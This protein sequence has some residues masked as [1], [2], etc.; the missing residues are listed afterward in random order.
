MKKLFVMALVV[1]MAL[2]VVAVAACGP[3]STTKTAYGIV[4]GDYVGIATVTVDGSG[5]VTEATF[6]EACQPSQK[7]LT[8]ED[9][10]GL[11]KAD[12]ADFTSKHGTKQVYANVK[13]GNIEFVCKDGKYQ[14]GGKDFATYFAS[15]ANCEAYAK[16]VI[17]NDIQVKIGGEWKK[18]VIKAD[19]LLK[20]KNGYWTV[21]EGLGW[22]GNIK[23]ICDYVVANG[24]DKDVTFTQ[25]E[26]KIWTDS[27]KVSVGATLID[28]NDYYKVLKAAYDQK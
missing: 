19:N 3:T 1:V 26:D 7:S 10:K 5:K 28:F 15:E 24:L 16:A 21:S 11:D 13:V 25:G 12:Y 4:H 27:N 6:D 14:I 22:K 2:T 17:A 18:D 20:S 8:A 23:A 9:L